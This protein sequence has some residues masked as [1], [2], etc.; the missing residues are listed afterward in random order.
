GRSRVQSCFGSRRAC[1]RRPAVAAL[2]LR[3]AW[4][5]VGRGQEANRAVAPRPFFLPAL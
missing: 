2:Q 3:G 5:G 4:A 1:W